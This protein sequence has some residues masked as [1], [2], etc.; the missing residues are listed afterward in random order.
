[1]ILT[2]IKLTNN[3]GEVEIEEDDLGIEAN[4]EEEDLINI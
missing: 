1:M 4:T 3:T 2:I